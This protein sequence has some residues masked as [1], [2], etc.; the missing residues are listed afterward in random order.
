MQKSYPEILN[1][2]KFSDIRG[3]LSY[4]N[5]FD[6]LPVKRFYI[7]KHINK[8]IIRAWQGHRIEHKYFMCIKGSFVV[9]WKKIDDFNH[10]D[11]NNKAEYIILKKN[12]NKVLSV[13]PGFANGLKALKNNSELLVFSDCSLGEVSDDNYRYHQSFWL[14]W[15][16]F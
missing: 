13:P 15:E 11:D 9:A 14:D 7:L 6:M 2:G 8:S 16:Q 4:N 12:D 5:N 10:P 3:E 1:G